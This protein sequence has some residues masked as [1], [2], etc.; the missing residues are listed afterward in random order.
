METNDNLPEFNYVPFTREDLVR[1]MLERKESGEC[2]VKDPK[3]YE[4]WDM[5]EV[6]SEEYELQL[7][8]S[9]ELIRQRREKLRMISKK[10]K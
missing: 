8:A 10:R 9:R 5:V 3:F 2:P 4:P 6:G 7:K 1:S